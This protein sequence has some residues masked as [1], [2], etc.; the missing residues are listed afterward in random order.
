MEPR[1][2]RRR[3]ETL[4]GKMTNNRTRRRRVTEPASAATLS[5][6]VSVA[7]VAGLLV[8]VRENPGF[9]PL[10]RDFTLGF[11]PPPA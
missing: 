5:I 1:V 7:R 3:R 6:L 10:S 2:I 11:I 8:C 4:G 9:A